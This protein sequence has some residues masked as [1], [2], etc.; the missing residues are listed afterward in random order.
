[1]QAFLESRLGKKASVLAEKADFGHCEHYLPV[2]LTSS[3]EEG[4]IHPVSITKL[5][6]GEL[7]GEIIR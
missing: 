6:N 2:R 4:S 1:M 5:V 3:V 7:I